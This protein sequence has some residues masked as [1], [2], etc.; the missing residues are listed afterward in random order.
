MAATGTTHVGRPHSGKTESHMD[1]AVLG[2]TAADVALPIGLLAAAGFLSSAGARVVDPLL[3]AIA[4][5]FNTTVPAVAV[6]VAAFTFPYGLCQLLL[7]PVGDRVGKLRVL[8]G[9]LIAYCVATASCAFAGSLHTLTIL[10]VFAGAASAGLIPVAMAYIGDFVPYEN[11]QVTLSRFMTGMVMA[12][13][14]A[15][16]FGGAF[17]QYVGWRSIFLVLS[18][19][20][21][22]VTALLFIR[23]RSLPDRRGSATFNFANYAKLAKRSSAR[24]LLIGTF[25]DGMILVGCFPF[26]APFLHER[27]GLSYAQ[28]GLLL[29]CFGLGA[30]TYTR[31]AWWLV[32][33]LGEA[34]LILVGGAT[35][36]AAITLGVLTPTWAPFILVELML[37]FGFTT[38]HG[39]LQARATELLPLARATAVSTFAFMLFM[40]QSVGAL[41][42]GTAIDLLGYRGAFGIDAFALVLLALALF[43]LIAGW[44]RA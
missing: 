35:M 40:G 29:S 13:V 3:H 24:L 12:V 27:F 20:S 23:L 30:L 37:G 34:R 41:A 5:D 19:G 4:V 2:R 38:L 9:A 28:V 15:G 39:V 25:F 42:M 44:H 36:T 16:P 32:P 33:K 8:F 14:L 10:R 43:R 11:R 18:A 26:L 22:I 7:G 6:V 21:L 1:D 31:L 17:G